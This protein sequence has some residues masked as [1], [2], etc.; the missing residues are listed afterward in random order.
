MI[1]QARHPNTD[2]PNTY[3][4][5]PAAAAATALTVANNAEFSAND[6]IILGLA[7]QEGAELKK[8]STVSGNATINLVGSA[9]KFAASVNTPV[10]YIKYNQVKFYLGDWS[11]RYAT[12]TIAVS[13]GSTI[14]TGIGTSWGSI[15][16][17]YA[18]LL[19]GKWHDI[20]SVDSATQITLTEPY[21]DETIISSAYALV[22]FSSQA[23]VDIAA[24]QTATLWDDKDALAEDYYRTEYY[25]ST[26]TIVSTRSAIIAASEPEG[27]T[28]FSRQTLEDEIL[29]KLGDVDANRY[30][31]ERIDRDLNDA[32]RMFVNVIVADVQEDY[33]GS[34]NTLDFVAN[35]FEYPL[36]DD[37]RK[38]TAVWVSYDGTTYKKADKMD[39]GNDVPDA[40]YSQDYPVYYIR[41]NV[42][43][44]KPTPTGAVTAGAKIWYERR[45]PSFRSAGDQIPHM[46]RDFKH[47][48]VSYSLAQ[49]L[50]ADDKPKAEAYAREVEGGK[51]EIVRSL[52]DRDRSENQHV[53]ITQD[54]D[55]YD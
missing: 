55:L 18:L 12:G 48:F 49:Q 43:G 37:F 54:Q 4:T 21:Q 9:L 19:N 53:Q 29:E 34:Y 44:I 31:R 46:L 27:F 45:V 26:S 15:T 20:A 28:E 36:F 42:M 39:I 38:L 6:Y 22:G 24:D 3:L 47:L 33:L 41:D 40:T 17:S 23:T 35:S 16:T 8:I 30:S 25:N 50:R 1:I 2:Q 51:D 14:V 13:K 5:V 11:A 10:V 52:K 32:L 7:G